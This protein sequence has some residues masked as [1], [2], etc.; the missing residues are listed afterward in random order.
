MTVLTC[1]SPWT[2]RLHIPLFGGIV[3]HTISLGT[4]HFPVVS[5]YLNFCDNEMQDEN[6]LAV[7]LRE[8]HFRATWMFWKLSPNDTARY[9]LAGADITQVNIICHY[10]SQSVA[11]HIMSM[12]TYTYIYIQYIWMWSI[13]MVIESYIYNLYNT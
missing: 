7:Q 6:P 3:E 13:N 5:F 4:P 2:I 8:F 9:F 11:R 1:C 12:Y 10:M